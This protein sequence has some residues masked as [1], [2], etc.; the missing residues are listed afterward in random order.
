MLDPLLDG[1][2]GD[3]PGRILVFWKKKKLWRLSEIVCSMFSGIVKDADIRTQ[4]RSW[5]E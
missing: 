2:K 3:F 4:L 1:W 5:L